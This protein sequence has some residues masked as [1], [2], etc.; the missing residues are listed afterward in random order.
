MPKAE[1]DM[2][3]KQDILKLL[4]LHRGESLSGEDLA[5]RLSVSRNAVWKAVRELQK[6]G[7]RIEG[8]TNKG[9][10]LSPESDILSPEGIRI[11]LSNPAFGQELHVFKT[12]DSTN[13]VAKEWAMKGAPHGT[14]VISEEQTSGRGRK[15][16]SFFSP[17]GGGLYI[18]F[19]LRPN[20]PVNQA[21]IMTA[22]AGVLTAE[23]LESVK[24]CA[25]TIKWVNDLFRGDKK[26]VGILTEAATSWEGGGI[27]YLVLGIGINVKPMEGDRPEGLEKIADS[28]YDPGETPVLRS[29]LAAL[30][31]GRV[32]DFMAALEQN[33]QQA[34]KD[35][36]AAYRRRSNVLNRKVRVIGDPLLTEAMA[37]DIDDQGFLIVEDEC[38]QRHTLSSGEVSVLPL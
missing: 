33:P 13:S 19:I 25:I 36:M 20:L 1:D 23:V 7:H 22:A 4:E 24:D 31:I 30:L 9:Y 18:S 14:V 21:V 37:V 16:R 38:G 26:I 2:S 32:F 11:Y 6:E 12:V 35:I 29:R 15:G 3:T 28:L 10:S 8:V 34:T 5:R 27:D 17:A